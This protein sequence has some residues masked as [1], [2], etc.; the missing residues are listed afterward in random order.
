MHGIHWLD[1][2]GSNHEAQTKWPGK[3]CRGSEFP[4]DVF[5]NPA[6]STMPDGFDPP[7][8]LATAQIR[9]KSETAP[10][11]AIKPPPSDL[12]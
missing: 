12:V 4:A 5:C 10:L 7:V 11:I 1:V 8:A 6:A 3:Y 9:K 2:F